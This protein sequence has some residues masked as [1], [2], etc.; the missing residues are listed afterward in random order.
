MSKYIVNIQKLIDWMN[1]NGANGKV[2]SILRNP[3]LEFETDSPLT[4]Q[5]AQDLRTALDNKNLS[6]LTQFMEKAE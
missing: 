6:A 2:T 5:E 1:N 3:W 4:S